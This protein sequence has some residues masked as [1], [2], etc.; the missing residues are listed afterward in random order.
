MRLLVIRFSAFGDVAMT[1]PVIDSLARQYPQTEI[2]MLSK[3]S[4]QPLFAQMPG[5]VKF[6]GVNLNEYAGITG[7][8]RLFRQLKKEKFDAV[9]DLHDVLRSKVL[10]TLFMLWGVRT[11]HIDKGRRDKKALTRLRN[12]VLKQLPTSFNRYEAVFARLGMPVHTDFHSIYRNGKGDADLFSTVTG[13]RDE[14]CRWIGVAPFAAHPGKAL[15]PT[16]VNELIDRLATHPQWT[17]FLFGNSETEKWQMERWEKRNPLHVFSIAG[18][19]KPESELALMS[20]LDVMISMDSANMHLA[21]LSHTPVISVWGATHP[22]AGFLGWGQTTDLAVQLDLPCRP[23]S[24]FGNKSC[25]RKDYACLRGIH[26]EDIVRKVE[27]LFVSI[28]E[29][30]NNTP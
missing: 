22:Y 17:I 18:K 28:S 1:I 8:F 24:I 20:Y 11:A 4:L 15:P 23:C 3:I 6:R 21:S 7:L 5:N 27:S 16:T 26:A 25:A 19:L 2:V 30:D 14:G 12:K 9:S 10:R 29:K 13:V